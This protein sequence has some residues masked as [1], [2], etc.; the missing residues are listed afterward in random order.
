[1]SFAVLQPSLAFK[2]LL[3]GYCI[4]AL[5]LRFADSKGRQ[6]PRKAL[7]KAKIASIASSLQ[8]G[9]T[10]LCAEPVG[11]GELFLRLDLNQSESHSQG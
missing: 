4:A 8:H 6:P 10:Q 2:I 3:I 11:A 1:M 7:L 5:W 9:S